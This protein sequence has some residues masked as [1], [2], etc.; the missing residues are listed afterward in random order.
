MKVYGIS[1]D[2]VAA[3]AAFA[4]DQKVQY[5]LLSDPDGGVADK[6]GVRMEN[7]PMAKRITFVIDEKGVLRAV[8]DKVSVRTH[9]GDLVALI[10]KLRQ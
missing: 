7:R 8:D 3:S 10:E 6:Y 5:A 4:K 2:D 9:G 1:L